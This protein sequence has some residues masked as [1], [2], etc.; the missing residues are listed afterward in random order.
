MVLWG[1]QAFLAASL[2]TDEEL[3][4][5]FRQRLVWN[6]PAQVRDLVRSGLFYRI[7][8]PQVLP[9]PLRVLPRRCH[10]AAQQPATAP[11]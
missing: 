3:M 11:M 10:S 5:W 8:T 9:A 4:A 1:G 2:K 6:D 7:Y